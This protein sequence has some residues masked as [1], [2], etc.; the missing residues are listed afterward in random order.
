MRGVDDEHVDA[1]LDQRDGP[2]DPGGTG[3]GGGTDPE[4]ALAVL[5]G[6]R[7]LLGLLDVLDGHQADQPIGVVDDQQLLDA[8]PVQQ[9]HRLVARYRSPAR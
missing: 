5:D 9:L 2:V 8:V 7:V 1:G 6:M 4:P 3:A